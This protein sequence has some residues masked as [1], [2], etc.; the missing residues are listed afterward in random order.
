MRGE[1]D[2]DRFPEA[3]DA[4]PA[5]ALAVVGGWSSGIGGS[6]TPAIGDGDK[7]GDSGTSRIFG[8]SI[9]PLARVTWRPLRPHPACLK[10]YQH[11]CYMQVGL[12]A[13]N[14]ALAAAARV[15]ALPQRPPTL[16]TPP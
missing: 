15:I 7:S 6:T 9:R 4:L 2:A 12:C 16:R 8:E 1:D 13:H 14:V 3:D 11:R 5:V 10:P